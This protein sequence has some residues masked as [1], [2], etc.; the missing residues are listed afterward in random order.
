V[1]PH[2]NIFAIGD[3]SAAQSEG[4]PVPGLAPAAKQ[5]GRYVGRLI[6]ARVRNEATPPAFSYKHQGDLAVIGRKSA[7]VAMGRLWLSGFIAWL[8]WSAVHIL[9]LIGFRSKIVV[10][11]EWLWSF[12][13]RQRSARLIS[14]GVPGHT[15]CPQATRRA[16]V[17]N[18][19]QTKEE[20]ARGI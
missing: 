18:R 13:T 3:T 5:M 11:F 1:P 17:A 6:A 20:L 2:E 16:F 10:A 4:R 9:F 14:D 19:E 7:V 15:V 8:F 12:V